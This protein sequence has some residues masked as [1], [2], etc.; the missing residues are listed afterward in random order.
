[1]NF[2]ANTSS[3]LKRTKT[4]S[5]R[6]VKRATSAISLRMNY[7]AIVENNAIRSDEYN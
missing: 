5:L 4:L 2:K 6:V 1:M 7:K 3:T